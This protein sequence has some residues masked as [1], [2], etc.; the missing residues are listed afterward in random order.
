VGLEGVYLLYPAVTVVGSGGLV[1]GFAATSN[2]PPILPSLFATGQPANGMTNSVDRIDL[3]KAGSSSAKQCYTT[4]DGRIICRFGDYF[5]ASIDADP[6]DK[7]A[8]WLSGQYMSG[9]NSWSTY[10]AKISR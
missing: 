4:D 9:P 10:I 6:V 1:I 5:G 3:I 8:A 2:N 7:N